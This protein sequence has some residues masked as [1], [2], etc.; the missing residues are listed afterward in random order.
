MPHITLLALPTAL[1]SS[2][3]L[4]MEM[5]LA[6]DNAARSMRQRTAPLQYDLVGPGGSEIRT[7]SGLT[8]KLSGEPAGIEHTD[9]LIVPAL[10]RNPLTTLRQHR[11]LLPWLQQLAQ[12]GAR[13]CAV[14]TGSFLLAE[15]GLLDRHPATT[16]W[17]YFEQFAQRYPL[18]QLQRRHLLTEAN[19]IFCAGSINS[20]AD[21]TIHFIE[22][23]YGRQLARKVEAQFSP[24]MRR[25]FEH[26]LYSAGN[27]D[28]HGDELVV[29]AQDVLRAQYAEPLR[30]PE[31]A[32]QLG[33][34]PRSLNR[35]F[36]QAIGINPTEYL[37]QQ[38]I[39]GARELLRTS[40]LAI[41]EVAAA[42]G[43]TDS[44]YFC[45][46]FKNVMKQTPREYRQA[47]R[48][49]LFSVG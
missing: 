22:L 7:A 28:V 20:V 48:G 1:A 32:Q 24:E 47:V 15:A 39:A 11:E 9:L 21:L 34:S 12:R 25:P 19:G 29:Q 42:V 49:K 27:A 23:F 41:A 10:W 44:G 6:A 26:H 45:R 40:N 13:L 18:V 36:Q 17:F 3:S 16:H 37:Q 2:L 31:L 46:L 43:Y 14:G 5:L 4:P 8:L 38:R 35:R 30:I 33:L